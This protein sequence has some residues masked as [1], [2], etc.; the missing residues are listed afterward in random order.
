MIVN[1]VLGDAELASP[2]TTYRKDYQPATFVIEK[3]HLTFK[4][5]PEKTEVTAVLNL[6]ANSGRQHIDHLFLHGRELAL[7]SIFL[8]GK[9]LPKERYEITEEGLL[10]K[11]L[12]PRFTLTCVTHIA[13]GSNTSLEGLYKSRTIYCTQCEAEGFRKITYYLDRPDA[14]SEFTTTIIATK[15]DFPVL[16]SNGN[17]VAQ[18]TFNDGTHSATWHD[19]F[20]K[21]A[22]LFAL[23]AGDLAVVQDSFTTLS[24]R[25]VALKIFVEAKDLDKCDH[26]MQSLKNAMKWDEEVYGREYDLD[27]FMIVAVDDFNMGAMENKG[28]NI[29]NTSCVLANGKTTTDTAFSRVEGVVAHE[30]FHNWSGNR[31]TCRDWFQLSLKEGFTVFRDQEFS[32]AMG[33]PTVKRV[34]EVSFLRTFQFAEDAG[35]MA[36]PVRPPSYIEISNFYTLTVYEKGAEIVRMYR[37]LLGSELFRKGS[38][39]YFERHD[40]Q[41]VTIEDF[42]A[43]MADASGRDFTQ[44]RRWYSQAGTPVVKAAGDYDPEAKTFT[45]N[46]EQYC[47][48]TPEA[49]GADKKPFHIPVNVALLGKTGPLPITLDGQQLGLDEVVLE[50]TETVQSFVFEEVR[51]SPV[52]SLFRGFSAPV[53]FAYPYKK[54]DLVS[55]AT[56][57]KDGFARFEALQQLAVI[58]IFDVMAAMRKNESF[59]IDSLLLSTLSELLGNE[60]LD[61]AMVALMCTLPSEAYMSGLAAPIEVDLIHRACSAVKLA[62][63][64]QCE[65]LLMA[66]YQRCLIP[67]AYVFN[68]QDVAKRS[69]KKVAL[70]YLMTNP[71]EQTI[72]LAETQFHFADNMT[73]EAAA[74]TA[75][76]NCS[77]QRVAEARTR[78]LSRF[79]ERWRDEALVMNLWLSIQAAEPAPGALLRVKTLMQHPAY[80][81]TN[82]NKIRSIVGVFCNQNAI[83]FHAIEGSG[84]EF[85]ADQVIALNAKN[86]QIAARLLTPLTKWRRYDADRQLLMRAQLERIQKAPSLSKD[87]YEVLAKSI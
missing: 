59:E 6:V 9:L 46:F 14:L 74:L 40:G 81:G 71:S 52:P 17:L 48:D 76:V 7:I 43:A 70:D 58:A 15:K 36:H 49:K 79:Y 23:V 68:A 42:T 27:I 57:D 65:P 28:L 80:D 41:A 5:D 53:K 3:T 39:I 78:A 11:Q 62:I 87:V 44:F 25:Q 1:P 8:D 45:L 32:A 72:E 10:L 19:P 22:Y 38:D 31:V 69:L 83:N 35:P 67:G 84:Y 77:D 34:E 82:P 50:V 64:Q 26:A 73:D 24:G 47:P 13:P 4:L 30:Y 33:S 20:K 66:A 18:E 63:A 54:I 16:L 60:K 85:L 29:F 75:L 37:T 2:R 51:E 55:I 86:P 61:P 21:P 56:R 12:P